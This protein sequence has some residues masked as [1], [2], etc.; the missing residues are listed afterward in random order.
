[1]IYQSEQMEKQAIL[2]TAAHMCAAARTAPKTRGID[3]IVT[4]VLTE[5]EKDALEEKMQEIAEREGN[6]AIKEW[7]QRDA[8]NVHAA[9]AVMLVGAKK[10]YRGVQ[11]CG[12]CGFENCGACKAAGAN[13]AYIYVDL[14]IA[15][16]S[17]AAAAGDD[18][19]DSRIMFS[20][21]KAAMELAYVSEDIVWQGIPLS[22]GGKNIFFDRKKKG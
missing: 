6:E 13:C 20:V 7:Y 5:K 12:F 1:M 14:G 4:L 3:G 21:G 18:R 11:K 9:G 17:A 8:A 22:I 19:V 10:S 2:Q 15:L 16:S